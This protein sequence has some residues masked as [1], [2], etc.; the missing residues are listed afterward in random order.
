MQTDAEPTQALLTT[1]QVAKLL[2]CSTRTVHRLRDA[3][4]F[5]PAIYI[6][7]L[8][9]WRRSDIESFLLNRDERSSKCKA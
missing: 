5:P 6:R 8:V 2:Q 9:R 1:R 7:H 3:G 4:R